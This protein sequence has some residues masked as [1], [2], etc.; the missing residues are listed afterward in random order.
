LDTHHPEKP[1][2]ETSAEGFQ[3]TRDPYAA[4]T[5]TAMR[6]APN[7]AFKSSDAGISVSNGKV[8]GSICT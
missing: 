3:N 7:V 5:T 1:I 8:C 2:K 6:N 4:E